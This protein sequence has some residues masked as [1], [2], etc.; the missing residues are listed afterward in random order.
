MQRFG[1]SHC[2]GI[3]IQMIYSLLHKPIPALLTLCLF[4]PFASG[5]HTE[6]R[7]N[8]GSGIFSYRGSGSS[9]TSTGVLYDFAPLISTTPY[10]K[11]PGFSYSFGL[12]VQ[13]VTKQNHV[14]GLD[15]SFERLKS[16]KEVIVF[17]ASDVEGAPSPPPQSVQVSLANSFVTLSPFIGQRLL[18]KA[19]TLD[20]SIKSDLA[21]YL[22][23]QEV[24]KTSD[25]MEGR[26]IYNHSQRKSFADL[27]PGIQISATYKKLGLA[28]GYSIGLINFQPGTTDK[29]YTRLLSTR[30]S[31]RLK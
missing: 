5:Q 22:K 14:F 11:K 25:N 7:L 24:I 9:S 17:V 3:K 27:R 13:Q 16:K 19:I 23:N 4:G 8:A 18:Y 15:L 10:G 29:A 20:V 1:C 21:Y 30:V 26:V 28:A 6:I 2:Q 12:Q 31:Y